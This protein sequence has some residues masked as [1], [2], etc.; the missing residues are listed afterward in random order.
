MKPRHPRKTGETDKI[1]NTA[2]EQAPRSALWRGDLL[3]L[4]VA[5]GPGAQQ[6]VAASMGWVYQAPDTDQASSAEDAQ[7]PRTSDRPPSAA[8]VLETPAARQRWVHYSVTLRQ[9][10]QN[11]SAPEEMAEANAQA[12]AQALA[13]GAPPAWQPLSSKRRLVVLAEKQLRQPYPVA[14]WD[15]QRL[16]TWMVRGQTVNSAVPQRQLRQQR[17]FWRGNAMVIQM[18]RHTEALHD[19]YRMLADTVYRRSGKRVP[20]YSYDPVHGWAEYAPHILPVRQN[21]PA[22]TGAPAPPGLP[23]LWR[24]L[25]APP[26]LAGRSGLALGWPLTAMAWPSAWAPRSMLLAWL[27]APFAVPFSAPFP[28]PSADLERNPGASAQ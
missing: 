10:A 24:A 11:A 2:G 4:L 3:R 1:A 7:E 14:R 5:W 19:D 16:V 23:L 13:D 18:S 27:P 15:L 28:V 25:S 22:P 12:N 21:P 20:I 6:D 8:P 26:A 9:I 17:L